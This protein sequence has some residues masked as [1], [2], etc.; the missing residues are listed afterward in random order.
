MNEIKCPHCGQVFQV[1]ESDFATIVKQVRDAEFT[2]EIK[3]REKL[4][5]T[6]KEQAVLL[7]QS[8]T[9]AEF[10]SRLSSQ[11]AALAEM[12]AKLAAAKQEKQLLEQSVKAQSEAEW[13]SKLNDERT[14]K[15]ALIAQL[16]AKLE[17]RT[18]SFET[19]KALAVTQATA[20]VEKERDA[21]AAEIRLKEAEKLQ[22]E[23]DLK[24]QMAQQLRAKDDLIAYK[25]QEIERYRDYKARLSTKML[26]ET[27]EQ[28]CETEFN[29]LRATAFPQAYFEKDNDAS[30]GSKGDYIFRESDEAGNEIISIMFEMKNEQDDSVHKHKN[31]DFF[32]KL[33]SDRRKKHCEYAVL[34]TLLEPENELYNA[35]IV[36]VSYRYEKMYVI[37]PQFFIPLISI[38]RNAALNAQAY[39][40][41][42][43]LVRQQNID[44]T[45][46]E[47][48]IDDFKQKFG[49]NYR[50]AS[51][52]FRKA[53]DEIDKTIDHLMK[54]KEA[55]L[56]S[57]NNLRLANDKAEALTI[58]R[59]TRNNPTM[60]A[61]FEALD[62]SDEGQG[63]QE[64][65]AP[66]S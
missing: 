40:A 43:A 49:R 16:R 55:L 6:E 37:R 32:K 8:N 66:E 17:S 56:G 52:K 28:H 14:E 5:Q 58:K 53:I 11:K 3:Q 30:Q 25:D 7:A 44:I 54:T 42:L 29:R 22:V 18:Q 21:Y 46:F 61:K 64:D 4:M 41:E 27:L 13:K 26:G 39:R 65:Q 45:N 57:E 9:Q 36:D 31:E 48:E 60:K 47:D 20:Q 2:R 51:D 35:G 15:D 23:H 12:E 62:R 59:L 50:L 24:A 19:E 38:L 10:Q 1:N 63:G 34:V 33:D